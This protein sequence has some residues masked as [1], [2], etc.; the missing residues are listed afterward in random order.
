MKRILFLA[1]ALFASTLAFADVNPKPFVIPELSSWQGAEGK[2]VPSNRVVVSAKQLLPVAEAFVADYQT[3]FGRK[4]EIVKGKPAPGDIIFYAETATA[5]NHLG[6]EGYRLDINENVNIYAA[7]PKGAY[8]ATRTLLQISE[9]TASRALPCGVTTDYPVYPLRGFMMDCGR[10]NIP[11]DYLDKLV[12][13]MSYYKM[14]T[15]Q[16]HLN[17]NGFKQ[18]FGGDWDKTYSAFRIE[19]ELF[20]GLAAKDGYYSKKDFIR[21]Q[22]DAESQFVDIIPEIDVPAHSLAFSN[23]RKSLGSKEYGMDHLDLKNPEVVPFLDSLFTEYCGG[24]DP[25]FRGKRVHIGTDEYSNKDSEVV[26]LFRGL[27]DHLIKHVES[28]GKQAVTWGALTHAN[29]NTPVKSDNVVM[30]I[31]YN[32]YADPVK[33]K[34]DGYQ[35]ICIPDG[36]VYIVPAAGYYYDYLACDWLYDNWTPSQIGNVKFDEGDPCLLGGMF[37][38]WND[39]CGNGITVKDIHHRVMPAMQTLSILCWRANEKETTWK[40]FD[41][42]RQ[43]LS[44]APGVDEL[45]RTLGKATRTT[46]LYPELTLAPNTTLDWFGS[47]IGYDY[48]VTFDLNAAEV[49]KGDVLFEGPN[50]KVYLASPESGKLAF[51]REGYL[52]EFDYDVPKGRTVTLTIQGNN[53]ETVLLVNGKFRQALYALTVGS[54]TS[55]SGSA[56]AS[57]DPYSAAKMYYQR[58]LVFPLERTGNFSGTISNLKV[59]NYIDRK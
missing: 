7:T 51:E 43:F 55:N 4:L 47:E 20:P 5:D 37:A 14:N 12:K 44:E 48:S 30:D 45:A 49:K 10:K 26:E 42:K 1:T 31:W 13:V 54:A 53:K 28:M 57:S 8:W 17:D 15:L 6:E 21:F 27:T 2:L 59:S 32:G 33:M 50:S 46:A 39:H 41:H 16:V 25:V 3:M 11:L 35:L 18:Y 56:G 19:S 34:E 36:Y 40:D 9:Q 22:E 24:T 29:G 58:T 38:V 23:Y 52:N